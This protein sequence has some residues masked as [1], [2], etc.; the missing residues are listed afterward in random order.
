LRCALAPLRGSAP[1][2][3]IVCARALST[4]AWEDS[5]PNKGDE[6]AARVQAPLSQDWERGWG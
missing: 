1:E 3:P 5:V 2:T 4:P 6:T